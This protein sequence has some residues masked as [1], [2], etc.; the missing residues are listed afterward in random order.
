MRGIQR[1]Q[2][3]CEADVCQVLAIRTTALHFNLIILEGSQIHY[4]AGA[5]GHIQTD[6]VWFVVVC[7]EENKRKPWIG[8]LL[9]C[10]VYILAI[11]FLRN[12]A[13]N[14]VKVEMQNYQSFHP[15]VS[16]NQTNYNYNHNWSLSEWWGEPHYIYIYIYQ[17]TNLVQYCTQ[18]IINTSVG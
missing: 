2:N 6:I 15:A 10:C 3:E 9:I 4:G 17:S 13:R 1:Q 12:R 11:N 5:E 7:V 18:L 14:F 16:Q 8:C